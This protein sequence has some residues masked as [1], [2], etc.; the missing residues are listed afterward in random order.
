MPSLHTLTHMLLAQKC[1]C[2]R[3]TSWTILNSLPC[4][5]G[6][7]LPALGFH[8]SGLVAVGC[9]HTDILHLL[10]AQFLQVC[11]LQVVLAEMAIIMALYCSCFLCT[12]ALVLLCLGVADIDA[13]LLGCRTEL[14][15]NSVSF[16]ATSYCCGVSMT[17]GMY[18]KCYLYQLV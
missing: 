13:G 17:T 18:T 12:M 8:S 7:L 2:V 16:I 3:L 9:W 15:C 10:W 1:L 11:F 4:F 6:A 5:W 14:G